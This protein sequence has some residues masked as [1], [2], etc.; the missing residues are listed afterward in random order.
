M[1]TSV[2]LAITVQEIW[3]DSQ[4]IYPENLLSVCVQILEVFKF[5]GCHKSSFFA[6]LFSRIAKL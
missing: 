6:I 2:C 3:K 1:K 4:K 5:R